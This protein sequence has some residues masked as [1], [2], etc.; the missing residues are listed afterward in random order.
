MT[1]IETL[2]RSRPEVV[3]SVRRDRAHD[4]GRRL[5]DAIKETDGPQ[6]SSRS[7][8][9]LS[10]APASR[11]SCAT[12]TRP[13]GW[14]IRSCRSSSPPRTRRSAARASRCSPTSSA[15]TRQR[16]RNHTQEGCREMNLLD[17]LKTLDPRDPGRWPLAGARLLRVADF[18]RVRG[19][20]WYMFVW[21]DDR[22]CS[23][24]PKPTSRICAR[25]SRTSSSAPP[26]WTPTRRSSPKWRSFGA[27]LRQLPGKTEVPNLLVDISQT[28]LAAGLQEKLFQP[29]EEDQGLLCRIADQDPIG[30]Q[31]SPVRQLRERH[32]GAAAH[33]HAARH[34]DQAGRRARTSATTT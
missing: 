20:A 2:Q 8:A 22:P 23:R 9:S 26:I 33:R 21:S 13:P 25:N 7:T 24:R 16:R 29:A 14:I 6:R 31:L 32:R 10:R 27:M 34:R 28:G 18:R 19:L 1:I 30:R 17:Q 3:H 15:W 4:S 5:S 11:R 12:S